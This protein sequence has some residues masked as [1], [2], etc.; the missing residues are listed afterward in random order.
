MPFDGTKLDAVTQRLIRGRERIANGWCQA[1]YGADG[2]YCMHG[3]IGGDF[4]L[5]EYEAARERL[6]AA[7]PPE[8][9]GGAVPAMVWNDEPGRTVEEVLAVFDRAIAACL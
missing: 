3:A 4:Q 8:A 7:L 9:Q 2:R 1:S 5:G 6:A